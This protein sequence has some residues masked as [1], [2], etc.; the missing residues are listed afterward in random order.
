MEDFIDQG[1]IVKDTHVFP[2]EKFVFMK[3]VAM[4][5]ATWF[6]VKYL[7]GLLVHRL[8]GFECCFSGT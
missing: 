5:I 8:Y 6:L 3:D 7:K 4:M 1:H 2:T